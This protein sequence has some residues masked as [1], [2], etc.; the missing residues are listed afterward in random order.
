MIEICFETKLNL[1]DN[2][3]RQNIEWSNVKGN[4]SQKDN[5][6]I[7]KLDG[8]HDNIIKAIR[9]IWELNFLYAG[10]FYKPI[11]YIEDIAQKDLKELYLLSFYKTGEIWKDMGTYLVDVAD[12]SELVLSSYYMFRNKGRK[13]GKMIKSL[14]NAFYYL[15]SEDYDRININH[16]LSL[17][18]NICDGFTININGK[19]NN[20]KANI[21][22]VLSNNLNMKQVKYGA[23]L[24]GIP[25]N[26]LF[27]ALAEERNEIDHYILRPISISNYIYERTDK[28]ARYVN[29]YF[30]FVI[31]LALR[32]AFLKQVGVRCSDRK[33]EYAMN[34]VNDWIILRCELAE[35]CKNPVNQIKQ[36]MIKNGI[37]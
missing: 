22:N 6:C 9:V 15:H 11:E 24:L 19:T 2:Q 8:E 14:I 37:K 13:S 28:R 26:K 27:D 1:A 32:I 23:D 31:E 33:I 7:L 4:I 10:Y 17:F 21:R 34:E 25:K 5:K 18:L 35:Q 30:T 16:R 36:K 12:F 20:I 29:W 3:F